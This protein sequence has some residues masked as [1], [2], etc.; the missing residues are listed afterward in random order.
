M[1]Y[2]PNTRR[3]FLR[4]LAGGAAALAAGAG[5]RPNFL[6]ILADDLG[7]GDLGC[8]GHPR[9]QSPN[10]DGLAS[11]GTRFTQFY[12]NAPVCSP[13]RVAF[14]TGQFPAQHRIH[15]WMARKHNKAMGMPD[16]LDAGVTTLP[17][18]LQQGG[19]TTGHFGKW[20]MGD[21]PGAPEPSA[22]GF[23]KYRILSQGNGPK[24][25]TDS[26]DPHGT[27]LLVDATVDFIAKRDSR[28]FY[29]NLW[30]RDVH[31]AL[32]PTEESLARYKD[33]MSE[34]RY[35]TAMQIYY[36]AVTEMDRQLGR[37]FA[38]L[39][40]LGA[41]DNTLVVFASDNG[42]ERTDEPHAGRHNSGGTGPF[43]G[44]KTS[45]YEGG[46]RLPFIVRWP[47]HTPRNAVDN[48]SVVS[49]V[50]LLPTFCSIAGVNLPSGYRPDGENITAALTGTPRARQKPLLWEW[51]FESGGEYV[52]RSP[53][54]AIRDGKWKLLLNPDR[55]RVELYD[56]PADPTELNNLAT[57]HPDVVKRLSGIALKWQAG[58]PEG[59]VVPGAGSNVYPWPDPM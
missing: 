41:A 38:K 7:W 31:A 55:S 17:R 24:I 10:L 16:W 34:N 8:Y 57:R 53:R 44:R 27:E 3:S 29:V 59:P 40:E 35:V 11:Q 4:A 1:S 19:Y 21:G 47:G 54:L 39:N 26:A 32:R 2:I 13:S 51:R 28:P 49:A 46:V 42:P 22:Y 15:N 9:I 33:L 58:L 36:A 18:L 52:N 37:L 56:I 12:A 43:R 50:D 30:S 23:D 25:G 48:T 5:N 14:T 6:F 20:H 45:L